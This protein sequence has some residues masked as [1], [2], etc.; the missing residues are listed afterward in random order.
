MPQARVQLPAPI[1]VDTE[2]ADTWF[3]GV[4][5]A[6]YGP[7]LGPLVVAS[8][9]FRGPQSLA[10][11]DWWKVLRRCFGR[12][13]SKA[14]L[15]IDDSKVVFAGTDGRG[16]LA[17]SAQQLLALGGIVGAD[18]ANLVRY[19]AETDLGALHGEHW[20]DNRG[21]VDLSLSEPS[22]PGSGQ[23]EGLFSAGLLTTRLARHQVSVHSPCARLLFPGVFNEQLESGNKADIELRL[24]LDLLRRQLAAADPE[25]QRVVIYVDRL[26][27]RRY[28]RSLVEDL[29]G[30]AF[31]FTIEE[32][33][34]RSVY[35]YERPGQQVEIH[36]CVEGDRLHLPIA[37]A[38]ILAKHLREC[39]MERFNA[40]WAS[41]VPSLTPTSG[42]PTDAP[43]FVRAIEHLLPVLNLPRRCLWRDK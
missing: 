34:K 20:F 39:C 13:G 35:R 31:V 24:I 25:C 29:A 27:G 16:R 33:A 9:S 14:P 4:D 8:T 28:Y 22:P 3:V 15:I 26:G 36:F 1:E 10:S 6:G 37:A 41:H 17:A 42:Y 18:L 32:T 43:R 38:S 21:K 19:I 40:F 12:N 2:P 7:N 5:E 11:R 30:D 23:G